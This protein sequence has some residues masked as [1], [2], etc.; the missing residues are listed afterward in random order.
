VAVDDC[1]DKKAKVNCAYSV[2]H[3]KDCAQLLP[4]QY[5]FQ[6]HGASPHTACTTQNWLWTRCP[7]CCLSSTV[8][9]NGQI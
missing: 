2:G 6:Q 8:H 4:A 9:G 5:I 1:I 3:V 7:E